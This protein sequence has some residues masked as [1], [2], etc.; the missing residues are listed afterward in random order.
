MKSPHHVDGSKKKSFFLFYFQYC[1]RICFGIEITRLYLNLFLRDTMSFLYTLWG[2]VCLS[3]RM[4]VNSG[5]W[6]CGSCLY[7]YLRECIFYATLYI[8]TL[9]LLIP[10][11]CTF[12]VDFSHWYDC[13]RP[14][15]GFLFYF[16]NN[17]WSWYLI[18]LYIFAFF[19]FIE[20]FMF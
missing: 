8:N 16:L 20:F 5:D 3:I 18:F 9:A 11:C 10:P 7:V 13:G 14:R 2:K 17:I 19:D 4:V 12:I 6:E 15:A 1:F